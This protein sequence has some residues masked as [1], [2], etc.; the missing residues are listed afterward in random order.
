MAAYATAA[1]LAAYSGQGLDPINDAR[2]LQ[3]AS[4]QVDSVLIGAVYDTDTNQMPTDSNVILGLQLAVCAQVIYWRTKGDELDQAGEYQVMSV[5]SVTLDKGRTSG[6]KAAGQVLAPRA[7]AALRV[8]GLL[9][10]QP[11]SW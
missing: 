5:G 7:M 11:I 6:I 4:D 9:P 1:Q 10:I 8:A 3:D 2:Q